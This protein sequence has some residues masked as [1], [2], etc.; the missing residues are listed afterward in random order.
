[1]LRAFFQDLKLWGVYLRPTTTDR[2]QVH[3]HEG[4]DQPYALVIPTSPNHGGT[5][6]VATVWEPGDTPTW[7]TFRARERALRHALY[8]RSDKTGP[9][10]IV[11][12]ANKATVSLFSSGVIT[13][14]STPPYAFQVGDAILVR[15][16]GVGLYTLATVA[17]IGSWPPY[18]VTLGTVIQ[19]GEIP[20][21]TIQPGD[22]VH[23][24]ELAWSGL[25]FESF[26]EL[27]SGEHGDYYAEE[28]GFVFRGLG[29]ASDPGPTIDLDD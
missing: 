16:L 10:C 27:V 12:D 6:R 2:R 17:A 23:K 13:L 25:T 4:I 15:R 22:D 29:V 9:L 7:Q 8:A 3:E 14:A 11:D 19:Y 21:D 24:V 18:T 20:A 28:A 26:P 1:M 5:V